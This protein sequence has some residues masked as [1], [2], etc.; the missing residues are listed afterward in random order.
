MRCLFYHFKIYFEFF[1][2]WGST[3]SSLQ[4]KYERGRGGG[5]WGKQRLLQ[6]ISATGYW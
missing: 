5:G 2:G 4:S 1:Y 3:A 6:A